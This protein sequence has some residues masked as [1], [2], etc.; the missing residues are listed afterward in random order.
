MG[1]FL[2]LL[3][4]FSLSPFLSRKHCQIH[5]FLSHHPSHARPCTQTRGRQATTACCFCVR[6][7]FP[8]RHTSTFCLPLS[9]QMSTASATLAN[10]TGNGYAE[11]GGG[12][13]RYPTY[14]PKCANKTTPCVVECCFSHFPLQKSWTSLVC[15]FRTHLFLALIHSGVRIADFE[16]TEATVEAEGAAAA[17]RCFTT[18]ATST[19]STPAHRRPPSPT[20]PSSSCAICWGCSF[21]CCTTLGNRTLVVFCTIG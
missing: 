18:P 4:R 12:G 10:S 14:V 2:V 5:H 11:G 21:C 9:P 15:L 20:S 16:A 13:D 7:F 6:A 19:S 3:R 17:G 8:P 1:I